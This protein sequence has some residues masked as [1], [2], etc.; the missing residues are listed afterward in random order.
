[1]VSKSTAP[2]ISGMGVSFQSKRRM[3][4]YLLILPACGLLLFVVGW[5]LIRAISLSAYDY[6]P[7]NPTASKFVGLGN[8]IA[9]LSDE[10]FWQSLGR[11]AIWTT[12]VVGGSLVLGVLV[13]LLLNQDFVFRGFVRVAVLVPWVIPSAVNALIWVW[14]LDGTRGVM[15]DILVRL[16]MLDR[17]IEWLAHPTRSFVAVILAMIWRGVPFF[18]VTVLAALQSLSDEIIE[19]ARV[20]G[21]SRGQLFF[22]IILPMIMPAIMTATLLR[23]IWTSNHVDVIY[24]MTGGGPGYRTTTLAMYTFQKAWV[25]LEFGYATAL[26]LLLAAILLV[27]ST[28]YLKYLRGSEERF[29]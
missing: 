12:S 16:G 8:Y 20:D 13:A 22:R 9:A 14:M 6:V 19:A 15:N 11:T 29:R 7:V 10:F 3:R 21:A 26:S 2:P 25:R 23:T 18:A 24:M 4:P 17:Y 27:L 1:M 5:P 28:I